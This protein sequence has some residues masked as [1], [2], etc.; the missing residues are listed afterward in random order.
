MTNAHPATSR[1]GKTTKRASALR[2]EL[3]NAFVD[4]GMAEL[5]RAEISTW[6]ILFRDTRPNG[7]TQTAIDDIAR[8]GGMDRSSVVRAIK[9]LRDRRMLKIVC[10]GGLNRGPSRY[11]VFPYT[12]EN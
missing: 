10:R 11:R 4:S 1:K 9:K 5:S 12:M 2:F 3:L 6:L 7:I 8:R